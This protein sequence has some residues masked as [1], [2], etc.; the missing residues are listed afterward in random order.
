MKRLLIG[1]GIIVLLGSGIG[2]AVSYTPREIAQAELN[3]IT[4]QENRM[5]EEHARQDKRQA[6]EKREMTR[7][8]N[9]KRCELAEYKINEGESILPETESLCFPLGRKSSSLTHGTSLI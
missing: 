5:N 9:A 7:R 8:K 3:D 6:R 2:M 1:L 4:E